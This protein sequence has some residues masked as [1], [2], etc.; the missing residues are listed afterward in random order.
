MKP[1]LPL[2]LIPWTSFSFIHTVDIQF[3][4]GFYLKLLSENFY[5]CVHFSYTIYYYIGKV[6]CFTAV[7]LGY[8][9]RNEGAN[10]RIFFYMTKSWK[11]FFFGK[12]R[13]FKFQG[14]KVSG[15]G[16]LHLRFEDLKFEDLRVWEWYST[17]PTFIIL[18]S[19]L[20]CLKMIS[21]YSCLSVSISR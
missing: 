16:V 15:F 11:L 20:F 1:L 5:N 13:R 9:I 8:L 14:F 12:Q 10:L 17:N 18:L 4:S 21:V 19:L 7:L 6:R 3:S 2:T